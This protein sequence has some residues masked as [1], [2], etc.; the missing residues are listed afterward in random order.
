[1]T[2]EARARRDCGVIVRGVFG[3]PD[4]PLASYPDLLAVARSRGSKRSDCV[5]RG[6]GCRTGDRSGTGAAQ[7]MGDRIQVLRD[8]RRVALPWQS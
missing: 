6:W 1:M 8:R 2:A 4:A 7:R 5:I 3:H